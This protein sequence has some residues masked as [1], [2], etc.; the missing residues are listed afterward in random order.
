[1]PFQIHLK[2]KDGTIR[3]D[4]RIASYQTP[5]VGKVIE[6][7]ADNQVVQAKVLAVRKTSVGAEIAQPLDMVVAEEI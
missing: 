1:M 6:C 7:S 4:F 3:T 2:R 5:L